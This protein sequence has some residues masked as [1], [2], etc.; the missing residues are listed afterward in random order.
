[1][2]SLAL[3]AVLAANEPAPVVERPWLFGSVQV[4]PFTSFPEGLAA[5]VTVHAIPWVDLQAGLGGFVDRFAWWVRGGVRYLFNDWRDEHQRG[6]TWR[7]S[8]LAGYRSTR[9]PRAT[10]AGFTGCVASDFDYFFFE[11]LGLNFQL[12]L[13]GTWDDPNKRVL[14]EL[15]LGVGVSF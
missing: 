15:R 5:Q 1:M 2:L 12:A 13:G 14:P 3:A 7:W 6:L 10:A 4:S 11:H 9:D 8:L